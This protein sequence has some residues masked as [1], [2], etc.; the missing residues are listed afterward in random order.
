EY[1]FADRHAGAVV[2]RFSLE[3]L[4]H[5]G[6]VVRPLAGIG[7][8]G[9]QRAAD[10]EGFEAECVVAEVEGKTLARPIDAQETQV[11]V[12]RECHGRKRREHGAYRIGTCD[13]SHRSGKFAGEIDDHAVEDLLVLGTAHSGPA[14]QPA[15][16][17]VVGANPSVR[18][19]ICRFAA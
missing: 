13:L 1:G 4:F 2:A 3:N 19:T 16:F 12:Y 18:S 6:F 8:A 17:I 14:V 15:Y 5:G 11:I 7:E 10:S 9:Q